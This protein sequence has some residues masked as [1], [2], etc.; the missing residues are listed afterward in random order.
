MNLKTINCFSQ[1]FRHRSK[2]LMEEGD[3][4]KYYSGTSSGSTCYQYNVIRK[5]KNKLK[6]L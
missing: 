2:F 3:M 4:G 5:Y 1:N 6:H